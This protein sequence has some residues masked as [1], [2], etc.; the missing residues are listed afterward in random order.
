MGS[1]L[2]FVLFGGVAVNGV[3]VGDGDAMI[4]TVTPFKLVRIRDVTEITSKTSSPF[5]NFT[6]KSFFKNHSI[7]IL[8]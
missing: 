3:G 8:F 4:D 1:N 6:F 2:S 7:L 5:K